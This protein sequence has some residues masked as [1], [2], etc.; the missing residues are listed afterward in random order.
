MKK[1][2]KYPLVI[3]AITTDS[4]RSFEYSYNTYTFDENGYKKLVR[5][6]RY[7]FTENRLY[8]DEEVKRRDEEINKIAN[9]IF[10]DL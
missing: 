10:N 9:E 4:K 7:C 3:I 2:T 5:N 8:S 6:N 1:K